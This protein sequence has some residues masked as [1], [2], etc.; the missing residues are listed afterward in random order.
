MDGGSVF[1]GV[2]K[3]VLETVFDVSL[4]DARVPVAAVATL[5]AEADAGSVQL[6][7]RVRVSWVQAQDH[8][9]EEGDT[10]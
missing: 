6:V 10:S 7:A 3:D 1:I 5:A 9:Y 4:A 2:S 8:K